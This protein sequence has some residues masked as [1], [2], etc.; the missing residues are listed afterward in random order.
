MRATTRLC[1]VLTSANRRSVLRPTVLRSLHS[2]TERAL[3]SIPY[4]IEKDGRAERVYDVY[5]RLL[6]DRIVCLM[7][8]V[9]V[10]YY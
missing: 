2:T 6:K 10:T 4:V 5:S 3:P 8:P 9:S 7:G 1:T